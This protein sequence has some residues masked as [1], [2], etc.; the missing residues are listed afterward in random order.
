MIEDLRTALPNFFASLRTKRGHLG[1]KS[2]IWA[3]NITFGPPKKRR[4]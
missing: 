3:E 4:E 1:E 2:R